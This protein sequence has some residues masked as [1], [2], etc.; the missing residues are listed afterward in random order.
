MEK[1]KGCKSSNSNWVAEMDEVFMSFM[2]HKGTAYAKGEILSDC[3][4][5]YDVVLDKMLDG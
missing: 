3:D 1:Y 5:T 2:W 4:N